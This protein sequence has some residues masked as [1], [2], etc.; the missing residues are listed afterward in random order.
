LAAINVVRQEGQ[1][2]N[3]RDWPKQ[4]DCK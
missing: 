1:V 3:Y 4:F 2:F